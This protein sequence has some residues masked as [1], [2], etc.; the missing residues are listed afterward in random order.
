MGKLLTDDAEKGNPGEAWREKRRCF[1]GHS[2]EVPVSRIGFT[3]ELRS[4]N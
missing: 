3:Q 4:K 1:Y 2:E